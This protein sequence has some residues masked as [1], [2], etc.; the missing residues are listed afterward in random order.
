MQAELLTALIFIEAN[1]AGFSPNFG[2]DRVLALSHKC[3]YTDA[4]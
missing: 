1:A 3:L 4:K 2:R